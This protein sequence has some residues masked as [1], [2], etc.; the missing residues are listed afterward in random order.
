MA[1]EIS[2]ER[3]SPQGEPDEHPSG[4]SPQTIVRQDEPRKFSS[5]QD[6][7]TVP[8]PAYYKHLQQGA[9]LGDIHESEGEEWHEA[10]QE[11]PAA[12]AK[13]ARKLRIR[14]WGYLLFILIYVLIK[15][16]FSGG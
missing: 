13:R 6:T 8:K 15:V 1:E 3:S 7:L 10:A 2:K 11:H 4:D 14:W 9:E 16:F 12:E 5:R